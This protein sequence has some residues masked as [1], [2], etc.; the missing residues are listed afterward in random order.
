MRV[1]LHVENSGGEGYFWTLT[2]GS[3]FHTASEGFASLPSLWDRFRKRVSSDIQHFSYCAFVEGQ[4]KRGYMPHFHVVTLVPCPG[5]LKDVAVSCG[6]GY[7][8]V[9]EK[10]TDDKGAHYVAKY[11]SKQSPFTPKGFRRVRTSQ[12]WAKL[13]EQE[14]PPIYLWEKGQ[15]LL[16]FLQLVE[17]VSGRD[18]ETLYSVWSAA[19]L[20]YDLPNG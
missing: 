18:I 16:E 15:T 8:A 10:I 11:A 5:R 4:P 7:Q 3:K 14:W 13:P 1:R 2:L 19:C 17:W 9:E 6:F 20:D 12:D